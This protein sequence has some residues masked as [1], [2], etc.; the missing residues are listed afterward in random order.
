MTGF[1]ILFY[2]Y[3]FP[4]ISKSPVI[5]DN[6]FSDSRFIDYF[7][8]G[9]QIHLLDPLI[10]QFGVSFARRDAVVSE[11]FL[12]VNHFGSFFEQVRGER[13]TQRMTTGF[14]ARRL[15]VSLHFLLDRLN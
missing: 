10:R 5:G 3:L 4:F 12:D 2:K 1:F 6:P 11:K 9:L 15:C 7:T 14:D 8:D 13:M